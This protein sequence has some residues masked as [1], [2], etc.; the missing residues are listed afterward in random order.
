VT[1][2]LSGYGYGL[3]IDGEGPTLDIFH[4]GTVGGFFSC[5]DY[6]SDTKTTVVVFSNLVLDTEVVHLA[7]SDNAI[8]PS[9]GKE[10]SVSEKI[11]RGY[12]G[13]YRS[14]NPDNPQFIL[15]T[16]AEGHFTSRTKARRLPRRG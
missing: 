1:P 5:L 6:I 8:L 10:A 7:M 3:Q 13:H 14:S 15:L 11:L 9:Q 16:F 12:A 2:F 4:N